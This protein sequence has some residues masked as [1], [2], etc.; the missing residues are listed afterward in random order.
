VGGWF[1][2]VGRVQRKG[3]I[4]KICVVSVNSNRP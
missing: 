2:R 3:N 1:V 4:G